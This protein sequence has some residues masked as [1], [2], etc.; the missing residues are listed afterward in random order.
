MAPRMPRNSVTKVRRGA[1]RLAMLRQPLLAWV[2][3]LVLLVPQVATAHPAAVAATTGDT[4]SGPAS[5]IAAD[6]GTAHARPATRGKVVRAPFR[7]TR[8]PAPGPVQVTLGGVQR[9]S[10]GTLLEPKAPLSIGVASGRTTIRKTGAFGTRGTRRSHF[11]RAAGGNTIVVTS[12]ADSGSGTLRAAIAGAS[13]GDTITFAQGLGT[14]TVASSLAPAVNLTIQG[15]TGGVQVISGNAV[16]RVFSIPSGVSA[17]LANLEVTGGQTTS[18]DPNGG[19]IKNDGSLTLTNSYVTSNHTGNGADGSGDNNCS[20]NPGGNGG[21]GGGVYSDGSLVL[22]NS[23]VAGNTTGNGGRGAD[24][25]SC[26]ATTAGKGGDGGSGGGVYHAGAGT[27][28]IVDSTV[29]G[30]TTGNGGNGGNSGAFG[31]TGG[32]GGNGGSGGNVYANSTATITQS[33]ITNGAVGT[34]GSPGSGHYGNSGGAAG[35]GNGIYGASAVTIQNTIL[36]L[37]GSSDCAGSLTSKDYNLIGVVCGFTAGAHDLVIPSPALGALLNNGGPTPTEKLTGTHATNQAIQYIPVA[38]C[39]GTSDQRGY[40]RPAPGSSFCDIGSVES[41]STGPAQ[42]QSLQVAASGNPLSFFPQG[43]QLTVITAT[44]TGPA[45]DPTFAST[46]LTVTTTILSGTTTIRTLDA[47]SSKPIDHWSWDGTD[48]SGKIVP[49]GVYMATVQATAR[50]GGTLTGS[51]TVPITVQADGPIPQ[52][53]QLGVGGGG[54]NGA[55]NPLPQ[56]IRNGVNTQSGNF[57]TSRQDLAPMSNGARVGLEWT[58]YYNSTCSGTGPFGPGWTFTYYEHLNVTGGSAST[59][60]STVVHVLEDGQQATYTNP[61][62]SGTTWTYGRPAGSTDDLSFDASTGQPT[63]GLYKVTYCSH[64]CDAYFNSSGQLVK[65]TDPHSGGVTHP[66][67]T[68]SYSGNGLTRVQTAAGA[69]LQVVSDP[70]TGLI[71]QVS[72]LLGDVTRYSYTGGYLTGVTYS[73]STQAR[74]TWKAAGSSTLLATAQDPSGA[75]TSVGYDGSGRATSVTD[76]LGNA[77]TINYGAGLTGTSGTGPITATVVTDPL[78]GVQ[79]DYYDSHFRLR[80]TVD[81]A[82]TAAQQDV[83]AGYHP[84][85]AVLSGSQGTLRTDASYDANGDQTSATDGLGNLS[86]NSYDGQGDLTGHTDPNGFVASYGYDAQG[87][88]LTTTDALGVV[89]EQ[90]TYDANGNQLTS[91]D[92][93]GQVTTYGYD[94]F[95]NQTSATDPLGNTTRTAYDGL[96]RP[97]LVT[98]AAGGVTAY[99]Y[100]SMGRTTAVTDALGNVTRYGYDAMGRTVAV[101]DAAGGVARTGYD[102]DGRVLSST[103][104]L[105]NTTAYGYDALGRTVAVTDA[106]GGVTRS[107]YDKDGRLTDRYDALGVRTE[108]DVYDGAG[109][110]IERDDGTQGVPGGK[111]RYG[112]D[113]AQRLISQTDALGNATTYGYDALGRTIAVT[114]AAGGV[115]QTA[116]DGDGRVLTATDALGNPTTYGYDALGRTIAVTDAAGGVARSAYDSAGRLLTATDPLGNPTVYGYDALG[117]TVAVTDALGNV[118]RSQYD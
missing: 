17:T 46:P 115:A 8:S 22:T 3:V 25:S 43:G 105:G 91:Q 40:A 106:L 92:A 90:A 24:D 104:A 62:Q 15:P 78:G 118:T 85:G 66:A 103:D 58:R 63:S 76:P 33:T 29:V 99:Q 54:P 42:S 59:P 79:D 9:G 51:A 82:G 109:Q 117:R 97:L 98:D 41:A 4:A 48:G 110:L 34:G 86:A 2:I 7:P 14:I 61:T 45:T 28:S 107:A 108:H 74:Y 6:S 111:A 75:T 20:G 39:S 49:S 89:A 1:S 5:S 44:V 68:L 101:T 72:D 11:A 37:N 35:Q 21:A 113:L 84:I 53:C 57:F 38:S 30:N 67:V 31:G 96:G 77:T 19:G 64:N 26:L 12:A 50:S 70:G 23:T 81:P 116:Y 88:P 100:D 80:R 10:A 87:D 52:P 114:D 69:T 94:A 65:L 13:S 73:D 32:Q 36:A 102:T 112:Y 47:G 83:D 95:G 71:S 93:S 55:T 56:A 16:T 18:T 27:L 60:G